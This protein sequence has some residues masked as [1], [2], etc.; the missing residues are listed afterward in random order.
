MWVGST[1]QELALPDERAIPY[2]AG[3]TLLQDTHKGWHTRMP[4]SLSV[5]P[6]IL[7]SNTTLFVGEGK[8]LTTPCCCMIT[9]KG[10]NMSFKNILYIKERAPEA[11]TLR[12][13]PKIMRAGNTGNTAKFLSLYP[14]TRSDPLPILASKSGFS[15]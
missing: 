13:I 15:R 2:S 1:L 8:S 12:T 10:K 7:R 4:F 5:H 14:Q 3:Y 9:L 11:Q 6:R